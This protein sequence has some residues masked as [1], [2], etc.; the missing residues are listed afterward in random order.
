S[1]SFN[2]YNYGY[3]YYKYQACN[4]SGCS[5]LSPWRRMY[6]YTTPSEPRNLSVSPFGVAE[7][8]S[9]NV[10]W[11]PSSGA[12]D[13]KTYSVYESFNGGS[14]TLVSTKTRQHWSESSYTHSTSKGADGQYTYRVRACSPNASCSNFETVS[15]TVIEPVN[16]A[17]VARN[18]TTWIYTCPFSDPAL[19]PVGTDVEDNDRDLQVT[20]LDGSHSYYGYAYSQNGW[21]YLSPWFGCLSLHDKITI[22]FYVT[23]SQGVRSAQNGSVTFDVVYPSVTATDEGQETKD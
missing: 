3:R 12:V 8:T 23:D 7:G 20:I 10:S 4:A 5:G 15:Q 17:P 11:T 21:I 2:H 18:L 13:G 19:G 9:Y 22:N 6:I 14:Q 16:T 1:A